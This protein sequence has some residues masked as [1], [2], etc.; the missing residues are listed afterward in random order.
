MFKI[1]YSQEAFIDIDN[2]INSYKNIFK[3]IYSDTWIYDEDLII[4]NYYSIWDNL[5]HKIKDNIERNFNK[6]NLLWQ[7]VK[8]NK[9]NFIIMSIN[10]FRL[11]IYY[12]ENLELKERYI[13]KIEFL[14]NK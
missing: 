10:N 5:Y 1:K 13:E 2:F 7:H 6:N 11:F 12:S 9:K 14:K 3:K 8:D 4:S